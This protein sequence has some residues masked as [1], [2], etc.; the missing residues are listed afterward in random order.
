MNTNEGLTLGIQKAEMAGNKAG[1]VWKQNAYNAFVEYAKSHD[2]FTVEQVR[3]AATDVPLP[4]D[5]R[6]WGVIVMQAK[7]QKVVRN[8]GWTRSVEKNKH[9]IPVALWESL[10]F[11]K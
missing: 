7:K 4:P 9:G 1:D 8:I 5:Q 11:S 2:V 6:A 3:S 10:V